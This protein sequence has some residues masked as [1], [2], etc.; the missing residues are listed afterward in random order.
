M[1][2][3]ETTHFPNIFK[4]QIK[5]TDY[6]QYHFKLEVVTSHILPLLQHGFE[7]IL[8]QP[9]IYSLSTT[10]KEIAHFVY[11]GPFIL[12]FEPP[13]SERKSERNALS[14]SSQYIVCVNNGYVS[15]IRIH[16]NGILHVTLNNYEIFHSFI[17]MFTMR[18]YVISKERTN[19]R[20]WLYFL[21]VQFQSKNPFIFIARAWIANTEHINHLRNSS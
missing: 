4:W 14:C 16:D 6:G 12:I 18:Y 10:C 15:F 3:V 17:V 20:Y 5:N 2:S 19:D 9:T 7:S 1:H 8:V 21:S 11:V 13:R